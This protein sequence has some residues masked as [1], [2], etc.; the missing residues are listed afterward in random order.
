MPTEDAVRR[1]RYDPAATKNVPWP[2]VSLLPVG[3]VLD[4][5]EAAKEFTGTS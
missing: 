4:P 1:L 5:A 3:P 2:F